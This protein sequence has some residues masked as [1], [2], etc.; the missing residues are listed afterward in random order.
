MKNSI[1]QNSQCSLESLDKP[2]WCEA[3]WESGNS[4][5]GLFVS[6]WHPV[7]CSRAEKNFPNNPH[8]LWIMD[9]ANPWVSDWK[10]NK[11]EG[12]TFSPSFLQYFDFLHSSLQLW[13]LLSFS[14]IATLNSMQTC[15][16]GAFLYFHYAL[17]TSNTLCIFFLNIDPS[18][19]LSSQICSRIINV[20]ARTAFYIQIRICTGKNCCIY[21]RHLTRPYCL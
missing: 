20:D 13:L 18:F 15:R 19:F 11:A 8:K 6:Y 7:S 3:G 21:F 10:L 16:L 17:N 4:L 14:C 5:T 9:V 1:S 2:C 12:M